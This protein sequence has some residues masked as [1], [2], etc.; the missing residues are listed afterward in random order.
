LKAFTTGSNKLGLSGLEVE[1]DNGVWRI[2]EREFAHHGPTCERVGE[3]E[4]CGWCRWV[5]EVGNYPNVSSDDTVMAC[6]FFREA[7]RQLSF[8][9]A[10]FK[11]TGPREGVRDSAAF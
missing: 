7:G 1:F 2:P 10:G 11:R 3:D 9:S 4:R 5:E 8:D 6:W